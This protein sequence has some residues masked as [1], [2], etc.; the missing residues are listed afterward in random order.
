[1]SKWQ[2]HKARDY[3]LGKSYPASRCIWS[4]LHGETFR[5]G[6]ANLSLSH[7][8]S[9]TQNYSVL[10][11]FSR[12]LYHKLTSCAF[13][14]PVLRTYFGKELHHCVT[15]CKNHLLLPALNLTPINVIWCPLTLALEER[16]NSQS[17]YT[18]FRSYVTFKELFYQ[19]RVICVPRRRISTYSVVPLNTTLYIR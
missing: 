2:Q 8:L 11:Y 14:T 1:M 18:I 15:C 17:P 6:K 5:A 13:K 10:T 7:L 9:A 3:S 4:R 19:P 12:V 16:L